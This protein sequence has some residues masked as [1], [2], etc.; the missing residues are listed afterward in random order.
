LCRHFYR[1][2]VDQANP[3][4]PAARN[5]GVW[6]AEEVFQHDDGRLFYT[7]RGVVARQAKWG[8][9]KE[10]VYFTHLVKRGRL[11]A[12]SVIWPGKGRP[13]WTRVVYSEDSLNKLAERRRGKDGVGEWIAPGDSWADAEG[14]A[15]SL[16]YM[17]RRR[18][19]SD[20]EMERLLYHQGLRTEYKK[21]PSD[22]AGKRG[23]VRWVRVWNVRDVGPLLGIGGSAPNN[24]PATEPAAAVAHTPRPVAARK[25]KEG[26]GR[27]PT[28][29][30]FDK[31][32]ADAWQSGHYRDY[33]GLARA[34]GSTV[35]EVRY[36][37]DRV[38]KAKERGNN[39]S[40]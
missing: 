31:R 3:D 26:A 1:R 12:L 10:S 16:R 21:V 4:D 35:G 13:R 39:T 36:A 28:N 11:E 38:R 9:K 25:K 2:R 17:T 19:V 29:P 24:G 30:K 20:R 18:G 5:P 22:W 15:F 32:V 34:L 37:L 14:V 40:G 27:K 23:G 7:E 8:L 33:L 6:I